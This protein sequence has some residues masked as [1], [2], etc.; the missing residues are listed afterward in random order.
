MELAPSTF[1]TR[2]EFPRGLNHQGSLPETRENRAHPDA[3]A[4]AQAITRDVQFFFLPNE[5]QTVSRIVYPQGPRQGPVQMDTLGPMCPQPI[6]PPG[7]EV[8]WP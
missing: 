7:P 1:L 4:L 2:L 6:G 8:I 3:L 5:M